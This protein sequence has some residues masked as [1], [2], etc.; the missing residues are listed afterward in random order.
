MKI[1][2]MTA[3][4]GRL[5]HAVLEPGAGLTLIQ[6]PN[7]AGKSTWCAFLR[8]MLYGFPARDRDREGHLAEKGRWQPWS[9]AA[10]EGTLELEWQGRRLTLYRGPKGSAAWGAF[11]AVWTATGE[12]V[13]GLTA[14]NC[15]ETLVGVSREVFERTA[16]VGEEGA[17]LSSSADL[18]KRV[19]AL[20]GTGEEEVSYSQVERRLKDWLNRRKSNSRNGLLPRLEGELAEVDAAL[21]RQ[22]DTLRRCQEAQGKRELLE[23]EKADLEGRLAAFDHFE[24]SQQAQRRAGA[25]EELSRAQRALMET[26]KAVEGLPNAENLRRGQADFGLLHGL[27]RSLLAQ[28]EA[29]LTAQSQAEK[30]KGALEGDPLFAGMDPDQAAA[31]AQADHDQVRR[32]QGRSSL[33]LF[34]LLGALLGALSGAALAC[35]IPGPLAQLGFALGLTE[36][37]VAGLGSMLWVLL[38]CALLGAAI[39]GA[40]AVVKGR[41]KGKRAAALL[42]EYGVSTPEGIL[43]RAADYGRKYAAARDA[44]GEFGAVSARRDGLQAQYDQAAGA[45]M[46]FVGAFDPR[47]TDLDGAEEALDRALERWEALRLAQTNAAA[48]EKVLSALPAVEISPVPV[49]AP[50]GDRGE[51]EARLNTVNADLHRFSDDAA[52]LSGAL[53]T[54]GDPAELTAR[55]SRLRE[56]LE[57][58]EGEYR[59]LA[60]ALEGLQEADSLLRERFSPALNARAGEYLHALTGGRYAAAA[61][62]RDFRAAAREE[63]GAVPRRDLTLSGGTAQQLYLAARLALCDLA[64]PAEEPCPLVLDDVLD[65]FDDDR[66]RRAV[67]VLDTVARKRQVLLF[68]CHGRERELA[69]A[70][71]AVLSL[72]G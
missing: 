47:V 34:L 6:A 23:A 12:T 50:Q 24:R 11:S 28:N 59:A 67:E 16:F 33:L 61:V 2:K 10:M 48:A 71:A 9:G 30:A 43:D 68:S 14:D 29:L 20:A 3:T 36:G 54:L 44:E 31:K 13:A 60:L 25:L 51:L 53:G 17:L 63:G 52:Q 27:N 37:C 41:G 69:P 45:L 35:I 18:E 72:P 42:A 65:A 57:R 5:D 22:E 56:E 49:Q 46:D 4:F 26:Q 32:L 19:A 66:A 8:A 1:L 15:G 62:K 55:R 70:G 58:R 39:G 38:P 7:E 64:L 40:I 21:D